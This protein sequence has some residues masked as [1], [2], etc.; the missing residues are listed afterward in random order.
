MTESVIVYVKMT[1]DTGNC[2]YCTKAKTWLKDH[3]IPYETRDLNPEQRQVLYDR[4]EL[5]GGQRT[6][7]QVMVIDCTGGENRIGGYDEL[8]TSRL[9]TLFLSEVPA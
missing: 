1:D 2:P 3:G 9:E 4:L 8:T 6:V 5:E 7:P